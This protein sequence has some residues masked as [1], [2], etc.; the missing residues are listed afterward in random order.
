MQFQYLQK[1]EPPTELVFCFAVLAAQQGGVPK[2]KVS[3]C[4]Y[5]YVCVCVQSNT[6]PLSAIRYQNVLK[7]NCVPQKLPLAT[8]GLSH[9]RQQYLLV[10]PQLEW[11]PPSHQL[12]LFQTVS[13]PSACFNVL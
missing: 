8:P 10:S 3:V 11:T 5:V 7:I 2:I 12:I 9:P 13:I 1:W 6:I 4:V